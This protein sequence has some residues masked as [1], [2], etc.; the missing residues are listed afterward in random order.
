MSN[1][2]ENSEKPVVLFD[3]TEDKKGTVKKKTQ[4]VRR[5]AKKKTA[6]KTE[7]APAAGE[8]KVA[9]RK[10]TSPR[11]KKKIKDAELGKGLKIIP[12]GG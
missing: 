6:P 9:V 7:E 10:T 12:L 8:N 5:T 3:N 2:V 4:S 11:S 1:E